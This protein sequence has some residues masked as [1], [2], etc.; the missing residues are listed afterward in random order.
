MLD[1]IE[2]GCDASGMSPTP[3]SINFKPKWLNFHAGANGGVLDAFICQRPDEDEFECYRI[4]ARVGEKVARLLKYKGKVNVGQNGVVQGNDSDGK[5]RNDP[6]QD[7]A[8]T[9]PLSWSEQ[10]ASEKVCN[11]EIF[12]L[13]V[14]IIVSHHFS[15]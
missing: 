13:V 12:P 11:I 9:I 6:E 4:D 1:K 14:S 10:L 2:K 7:D 3:G 5:K 8:R 15:I